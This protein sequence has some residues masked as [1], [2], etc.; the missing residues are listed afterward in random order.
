MPDGLQVLLNV[1]R[2]A[3]GA[4]TIIMV[5]MASL[6]ALAHVLRTLW[7]A[8]LGA[9]FWIWQ[10][11]TSIATIFI[12][13]LIAFLG[14]PPVVRAVAA[15]V[16]GS[17]GCGPIAELGMFASGLIAAIVSVRMLLSF[18]RALAASAV[19]GSAEISQ[20]LTEAIEAISGMLLASIVVPLAAAFL[21]V[22]H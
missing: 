1:L 3:W 10:S 20:A 14:I 15:A 19:G 13:V 8:T 4:L 17:A 21:G 5:V 2:Q 6:G 12:L 22:C 18:V 9:R 16:P 11:L 7:A